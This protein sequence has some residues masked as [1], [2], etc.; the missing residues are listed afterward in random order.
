M[1]ICIF[2][3]MMDNRMEGY[4]ISRNENEGGIQRGTRPIWY[5][6]LLAKSSVLYPLSV[7]LRKV[8]ACESSVNA[9]AD[10]KSLVSVSA[11]IAETK[12]FY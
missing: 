8:S 6:I 3:T 4:I 12:L 5:T 1:L 9:T 10:E 2:G 11:S 7:R